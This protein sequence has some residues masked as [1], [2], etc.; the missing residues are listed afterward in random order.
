MRAL[1]S[2]SE[3]HVSGDEETSIGSSLVGDSEALTEGTLIMIL[4][5]KTLRSSKTVTS[6]NRI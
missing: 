6:T 5:E 2:G 4:N 3:R 1:E